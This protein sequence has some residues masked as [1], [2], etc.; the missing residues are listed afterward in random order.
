MNSKQKEVI[1]IESNLSG[2]RGPYLQWIAEYLNRLKF[3]VQIV[4]SMENKNHPSM[5]ALIKASQGWEK[6]K[7]ISFLKESGSFENSSKVYGLIQRELNYWKLLKKWYK[8][9][10]FKDSIIFLPSLDSGLHAFS[11]LGS[12]FGDTKWSGLVMAQKFQYSKLGIEIH[13][14]KFEWLRESLFLRMLNNENLISLYTINEPLYEYLNNK[15][16]KLYYL[17]E[18]IGPKKLPKKDIARNKLGLSE[19]DFYILLYGSLTP[20][21]GLKY[22]VDAMNANGFPENC[23]VIVAGKVHQTLNDYFN[24]EEISVLRDEGRIIFKNYFI[25]EKEESLLYSAS[26]LIWLGYKNHLGPSGILIQ[27]YKANKP[28][29]ACKEGVIGWQTKKYN[30]GI[31]INPANKCEV[32][33]AIEKILFGNEKYTSKGKTPIF[34]SEDSEIE[35]VLRAGLSRFRHD[36]K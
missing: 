3:D 12:P 19:D 31:T 13:Q 36:T 20:R 2:H 32:I 16:D 1:I 4:T 5:K 10:V 29:I 34:S 24:S 25:K 8:E 9:S 30:L 27:S 21:K 26:D 6:E 18:P 14:N 22:L 28:V 7:K 15:T 23:N 11:I 35:N 33:K 17:P